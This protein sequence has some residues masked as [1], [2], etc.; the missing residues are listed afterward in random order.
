MG[1]AGKG[2]FLIGENCGSRP[3]LFK[4]NT[5]LPSAV[6]LRPRLSYKGSCA[7]EL[8]RIC[9]LAVLDQLGT[10]GRLGIVTYPCLGV[11][12]GGVMGAVNGD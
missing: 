1:V 7:S 12:T 2:L 6:V 10:L 8:G 5:E 9:V 3:V 4:D 11:T